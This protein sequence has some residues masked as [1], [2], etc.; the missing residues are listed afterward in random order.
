MS[1][2]QQ[3][4]LLE[5]SVELAVRAA[6]HLMAEIE[7]AYEDRT[8]A[9]SRGRKYGEALALLLDDLPLNERVAI[10]RRL[11]R[12]AFAPASGAGRSG[13]VHDNV[14]ALF[15]GHTKREWSVPEIQAELTKAGEPVEPKALYN[16]INYLA[17]VGRLRRVSRG[18]YLVLGVGAGLEAAGLADD[19]TRRMTEHDD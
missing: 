19:G 2:T 18:Q 16:V 11:D 8:A 13:E 17:K 3:K 10:Q 12:V 15:K 5:T 1:K 9:D 14:V 6:L 7:R 4:H